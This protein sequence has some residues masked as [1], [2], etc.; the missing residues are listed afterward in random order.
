MVAAVSV[1]IRSW[2]LLE[3]P[4]FVLAP[5]GF[6]ALLGNAGDALATPARQPGRGLRTECLPTTPGTPLLKVIHARGSIAP[7]PSFIAALIHFC[8][9]CRKAL[10]KVPARGLTAYQGPGIGPRPVITGGRLPRSG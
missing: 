2:R 9:Q 6:L 8:G 4:H 1:V 5:G 10:P 3:Y 7:F